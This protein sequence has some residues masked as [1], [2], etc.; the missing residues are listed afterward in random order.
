LSTEQT[1]DGKWGAV[2]SGAAA[3]YE[4]RVV[5]RRPKDP[6]KFNGTILYEWLNVS[7][8]VDASPDFTYLRDEIVREGYAW[9]G[10]S[11]QHIGVEGG[12]AV[13]AVSAAPKGGLKGIDPAR[14]GELH[15]PGDQYALDIY[16]QVGRALIEGERKELGDLKPQRIYAVGESQSAFQLVTY[17]NAIDPDTKLFDAFFVHSRGGGSMPIAGG[18]IAAGIGGDYQIRSD[19]KSPVL[20]L[21][22]ESDYLILSYGRARQPDSDRVRL[23]D[24]AGSAHA[25]TYQVGAAADMLGCK[26]KPNAAPSHFVIKAG[27]HALNEWVESGTPPASAPRYEYTDALQRDADGIVKGGIRG[28]AVDVPPAVYTGVPADS[29]NTL[30][31]LFGATNP[32]DTKARYKD[33]DDY[34]AKV[35]AALDT[36]IKAGYLLEPD[37]AAA[38]AEAKAAYEG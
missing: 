19:G 5:L 13:V 28:P 36:M 14:Y 35:N 22:T 31:I 10:V 8:G 23:W 4:T 30:C 32:L 7:G 17:I 27:L 18:S 26:G 25:D 24:I 33:A 16:T 6:S 11:A 37:R 12:E 21:E 34:E 2:E 15:H 9:A 29:S 38:L 3:P 20:V 1:S